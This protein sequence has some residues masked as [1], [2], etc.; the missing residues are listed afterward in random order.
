[1]YE[2]IT[3]IADRYPAPVFENSWIVPEG[4]VLEIDDYAE[5]SGICRHDIDEQSWKAAQDEV[6]RLKPGEILLVDYVEC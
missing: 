4:G 2:L 1:M 5:W 3:E 6:S